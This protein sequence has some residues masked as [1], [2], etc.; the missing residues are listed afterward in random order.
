[1][2]EKNQELYQFYM[3]LNR[4]LFIDDEYSKL[5]SHND[6]ALPIECGQ[7]ISQPSLVYKM[8]DSLDL[9]KEH[10]V[11]E[12]G[13]GSG[14][15]TAFLSRFART[16]YTVERFAYLSDKAKE[17]LQKLG[18]GNTHFKIGDGS[19]GWMA[20]SPYD[21]IIVTAA[22]GRIPDPLLKQLAPGGKMVIPVGMRGW[23]ELLLIRKD[24]SGKVGEER[25]VSVSF[26]ELKGEYGWND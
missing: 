18:Y 4:S 24:E 8:T 11:L 22:A 5:Y 1:M 15:Q 13:T 20:H 6:S 19:E 17:R 14:Y 16:V 23:Q 3:N 26:V 10:R 9:K 7:T 25:L 21:R 2:M 12:I